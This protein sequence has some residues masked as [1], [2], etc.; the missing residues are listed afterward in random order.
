MRFMISLNVSKELYYKCS[1]PTAHSLTFWRSESGYQSSL[2]KFSVHA[3]I[4]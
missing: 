1:I 2:I 3:Y 4:L